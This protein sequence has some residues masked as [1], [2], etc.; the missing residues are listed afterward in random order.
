[1]VDAREGATALLGWQTSAEVNADRFSIQRS[2]D[3]EKWLEI[4]SVQA[5]A[6]REFLKDDKIPNTYTFIDKMPA[7]G[8]NLYRLK[9][10]DR[11]KSF[12]YSQIR[13]LYFELKILAY[14]NPVSDLITLKWSALQTVQIFNNSGKMVYETSGE[15]SAIDVSKLSAGAYIFKLIGNDGSSVLRKL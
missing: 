13:N 10:I 5:T 6:Q 1:M 12:A 7:E 3:G 9:M 8:E 2:Q 15:T 14:P 11:N 4:G